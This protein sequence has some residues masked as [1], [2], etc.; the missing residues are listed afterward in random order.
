LEAAPAE[1]N[2]ALLATTLGLPPALLEIVPALLLSAALNG[3]AFTLLA[4]GAHAPR[5]N[6]GAAPTE[7]AGAQMSPV[8]GRAAQ[9]R[10]FVDT[11]RMRHGRDPSFT[12][13]RNSLG[14]PRSTA[15]VYLRKALA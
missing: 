15:S 6:I 3:L 13:V 11:Y 2:T 5:Q 12:E 10:S 14:L 9:V 7:T 4:F 8:Q 1:R